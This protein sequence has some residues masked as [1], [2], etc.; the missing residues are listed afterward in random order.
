MLADANQFFILVFSAIAI[1]LVGRREK[2]SRW[3][4]IF[5]I[6][7][8]PFWLYE[9]FAE[10]Q[11]GMFALSIWYCISWGQGIYNYWIIQDPEEQT[12]NNLD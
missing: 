12:K 3:G 11:W 9:T 1:G 7:S 10:K 5:G 8:Q 6:A 2:W 4:Y